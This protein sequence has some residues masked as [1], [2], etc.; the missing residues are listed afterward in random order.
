MKKMVE[1]VVGKAVYCITLSIVCVGLFVGW[2]GCLC[3][4]DQDIE[5][6]D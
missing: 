5:Y 4:G 3:L 2:I 6:Y 1:K